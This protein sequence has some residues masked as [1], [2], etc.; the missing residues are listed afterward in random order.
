M[1]L[2]IFLLCWQMV[3]MQTSI[4]ELY[5]IQLENNMVMHFFK[6]IL[7]GLGTIDGTI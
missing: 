1:S 2:A 4:S 7:E 3:E 6:M 5:E